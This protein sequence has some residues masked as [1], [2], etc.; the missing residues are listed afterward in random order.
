MRKKLV[1]YV[2]NECDNMRAQRFLRGRCGLSARIIT[3]LKREKDGILMDGKI[4][5]T[6]DCV[7]AGKTVV[8]NLPSENTTVE[9][10][11]GNLKIAYEDDYILIAD[12]PPLMPVHPVKQHQTDTLANIVAYYCREKNDSFVFRAVNRLDKDTSGLVIIAKNKFCAHALKNSV[13]K[14]YYA[15]CEGIISASGTVNA[16]IGLT[17]GSKIVREVRSDGMPSIT[18]YTPILA[19]DNFTFTELWLETG[20]THQIRCHMSSIGHPL[21][22]DDLYGGGL[23]LITRQALHCGEISFIHPVTKESLNIKAEL[24]LDMQKIIKKRVPRTQF[25]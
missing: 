15:I 4:L 9:P 18:H 11:K 3:Q 16:P 19:G 13:Q 7:Q 5:R 8:I 21:L 6:I 20:R 12:K 17:E 25:V 24:P 22:G 10:I 1:F 23:E 14:I 2:P